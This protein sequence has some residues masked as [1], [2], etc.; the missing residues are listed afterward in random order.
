MLK[1]YTVCGLDQRGH[2]KSEG[3]RGY[4]EKLSDYLDNLTIFVDIVRGEHGNT[5]IFLWWKPA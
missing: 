4:I 5:K 1:D 2:G 3:L